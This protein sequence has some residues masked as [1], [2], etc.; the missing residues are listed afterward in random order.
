MCVTNAITH[1]SGSVAAYASSTSGF[2]SRPSETARC[3]PL[4]P[5]PTAGPA[6][7]S[8]PVIDD[9]ATTSSPAARSAPNDGLAERRLPDQRNAHVEM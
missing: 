4:R 3:P 2:L 8:V 1:S 7:P 5:P 9:T 6:A